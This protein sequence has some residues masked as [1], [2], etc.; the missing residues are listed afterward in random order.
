MPVSDPEL[1]DRIQR[2]QMP[3][4]AKA[5]W[6]QTEESDFESMLVRD[7]ELSPAN[8]G[9]LVQEYRKFLYLKA[10]DGSLLSPP[11]DVDEVWHKH[12]AILNGAW[13]GFCQTVI[14]KPLEHR[15]GLSR[16]EAKAASARALLLYK[17]EFGRPP[18]DIWPG[19]AA[20]RR[21]IIGSAIAACGVVI[22]AGGHLSM[23]AVIM[24]GYQP[25][26]FW[27]PYTFMGGIAITIF[28]ILVG[29]GTRI[30]RSPKCG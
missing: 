11:A 25:T 19:P 10:L 23:F 4:P 28:G 20:N 5:K 30:K 3:Q 1:W 18:T 7:M 14:G 6:W 13:G 9:R 17:K 27:I 29:Q 15:T 2:F 21:Y 12:I 22:A 8:A 26:V 24:L 16:S